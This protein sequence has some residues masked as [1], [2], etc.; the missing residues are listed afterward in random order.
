MRYLSVVSPAP[1]GMPRGAVWAANLYSAVARALRG[2][3]SEQPRAEREVARGHEAAAVRRYAARMSEI[4]PGF[5]A[6]LYAA[7]DRHL[8]RR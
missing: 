4:D 5:A 1:I 6:D 3:C 2:L 7:A 8:E